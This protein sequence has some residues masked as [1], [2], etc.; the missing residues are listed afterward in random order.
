MQN[1]PPNVPK[2]PKESE[3]SIQE[4]LSA[5]VHWRHSLRFKLFLLTTTLLL[6]AVA[7]ISTHNGV[8]Y[9]QQQKRQSSQ[10]AVNEATKSASAASS[11]IELW[12]NMVDTM[13]HEAVSAAGSS[14][15]SISDKIEASMFAN[16]EFVGVTLL[17]AD[18]RGKIEVVTTQFTSHLN[19]PEFGAVSAK[20]LQNNLKKHTDKM[21]Q[22]LKTQLQ[23]PKPPALEPLLVANISAGVR[24]D[25]IE[26]RKVYR[27]PDGKSQFI[28]YLHVWPGRLKALVRMTPALNSVVIERGG[29]VFLAPDNSPWSKSKNFV[30]PNLANLTDAVPII[31]RSFD[32]EDG[33]P[34]VE[35]ITRIP[36]TP[37]LF[38]VQRSNR[39]EL[40][41]IKKDVTKTATLSW[42]F[43]LITLMASF[44]ASRKMTTKINEA[45]QATIKIAAGDLQTRVSADRNDEV[46]LLAVSVNHLAGRIRNLLDVEVEAARQEKELKTAQAVQQTLFKENSKHGDKIIVQGHFEPASECAGDWWFDIKLSETKHLVIIA[47]ATGHGASAA[48]IVALACSYF[49]TLGLLLRAEHFEQ[50][51]PARILSDLN[52]L[53]VRSGRGKTTM[54]MFLAEINTETMTIRYANAGHVPPL[55]IPHKADDER[56]PKKSKNPAKSRLIPL[57]GGG[58]ML[59]FDATTKYTENKTDVRLG[60]RLFFYTDGLVECMGVDGQSMTAMDLRRQLA[61]FTTKDPSTNLCTTVVQTARLRLGNTPRNDD[62]TVVV[63]EINTAGAATHTSGQNDAAKVVA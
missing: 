15:K 48:L 28:A 44:L 30:S 11:T 33:S 45:I 50:R 14:A 16:R 61:E 8:T 9:W 19:A 22:N 35:V 60:D 43:V 46:G 7:G 59:G 10:E 3:S 4:K 39:A 24:T 25:L 52:Q 18:T 26:I 58:V 47:D 34:V 36:Q 17:L 53:L 57:L 54:T 27:K 40:D 6:I 12:S 29:K 51:G 21:F 32:H 31:T 1:R 63:A 5:R 38:A 2:N 56:L 55:L 13:M 42:I 23:K 41:Q 37:L 49:Q 20:D 62:I